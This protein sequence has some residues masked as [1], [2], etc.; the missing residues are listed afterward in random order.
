MMNNKIQ[1]ES[2]YFL[3]EE[4]AN[5]GVGASVHEK[6]YFLN[7]TIYHA[8]VLYIIQTLGKYLTKEY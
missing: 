2:F 7:K 8:L 6:H 5:E 4:G 1:F 3:T